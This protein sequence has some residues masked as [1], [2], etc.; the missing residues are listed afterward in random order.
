LRTGPNDT[1]TAQQRRYWAAY[2]PQQEAGNLVDSNYNA[3]SIK[4][5]KRFSKGL[6]YL[7][8]FTY[9]KSIDTGASGIRAGAGDGGWVA[10]PFC[11]HCD[12]GLSQFDMR[13]RFVTSMIY[14]V[15]GPFRGKNAFGN[16]VLGG[17]QISAILTLA[18]GTA[19]GAGSIGD[20]QQ[21]GGSSMANATLVSPFPSNPTANNFWNIGAFNTTDPSLLFNFGNVGRNVLRTPGVIGL[22]SSVSKRFRIIEGHS[23]EFRWEAFNLPN[24]PNWNAPSNDVTNAAAFGVVTSARQARD[25]QFGLKYQF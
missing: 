20:R 21:V 14:E 17:W 11:L 19:Y 16:K 1:R 4:L 7:V 25:M 23:L 18:D 12:R 3:G 24:H 5:T 10:N 22:D 2:G 8:G 6:T 13:K 15:P 9:G